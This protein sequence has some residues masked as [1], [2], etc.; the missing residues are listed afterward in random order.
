MGEI[1]IRRRIKSSMLRIKELDY[2]KGK[3]VE[4]TL[5]INELTKKSGH[6]KLN[7]AAG[8]LSEYKNT[9][10]W[11]QEKNAWNLAISEKYENSGC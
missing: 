3:N 1:K 7:L 6:Q 4:I 9:N 2:Y 11:K 5:K 10:L 8:M